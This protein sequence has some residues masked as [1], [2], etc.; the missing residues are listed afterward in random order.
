MAPR[1]DPGRR[2]A[3]DLSALIAFAAAFGFVEA[4]VVYDLRHLIGSPRTYD[5]THLHTLLNL[6]F[7]TFV[8]SLH[9]LLPPAVERVE[10]V[11]ESA[12]MIMLLAVAWLAGR[13]A[14]QRVGAYFV[15]FA[16]WDLTYYLSLR[17]IDGWPTSLFT[18]D[19]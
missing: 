5:F 14:R 7:I 11:R 16:V 10:V 9:S 19:V 13:T 2:R 4:A 6:G 1:G 8:S 3:L 15:A 18:R 12:T 17:L